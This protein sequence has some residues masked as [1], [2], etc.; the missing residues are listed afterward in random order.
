MKKRR[1]KKR[2]KNKRKKKKRK[3]KRKK[4]MVKYRQLPSFSDI[5][6]MHYLVIASLYHLAKS[7]YPKTPCSYLM[8]LDQKVIKLLLSKFVLM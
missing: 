3:K 8:L 2:K 4:R 1:K 7:V 5:G 6:S